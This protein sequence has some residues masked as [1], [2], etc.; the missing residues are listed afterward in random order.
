MTS[1]SIAGFQFL[2]AYRGEYNYQ[3]TF[4]NGISNR[5]S[6]RAHADQRSSDSHMSPEAFE[7]A[8]NGSLGCLTA[9]TPEILSL[10]LAAAFN[11]H[12]YDE[13]MGSLAM[14]AANP[15]VYGEFKTEPY[16][17]AVPAVFD[18]AGNKWLVLH[19]YETV[20]ASAGIPAETCRSLQELAPTTF[21][22]VA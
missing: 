17:L 16:A 7:L 8:V 9:T 12:C 15:K 13:Y 22:Q 20:R 5:L 4:N 6:V 18:V 21:Q 19:D 11:R 14:M 3:V 1:T 2:S 10:E